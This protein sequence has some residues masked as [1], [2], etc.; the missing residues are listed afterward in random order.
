MRKAHSKHNEDLCL[1][2]MEQGGFNDWVV[3]TAFYSA[4]HLT[5]HQLFPHTYLSVRCNSFSSYYVEVKKETPSINKHKAQLDLIYRNLNGAYPSYKFLMDSCHY[6]RY[7]DYNT[8]LGV[9]EKA[10]VSL[11]TIKMN[12]NRP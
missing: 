8:S 9:A 1:H 10:K 5:Q 6:A 11:D 7:N 2:L 3:T 4:L 12:C